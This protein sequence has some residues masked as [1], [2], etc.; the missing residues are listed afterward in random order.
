MLGQALMRETADTRKRPGLAVGA[1]LVVTLLRGRRGGC[2]GRLLGRV[3]TL[4]IV[5]TRPAGVLDFTLRP[6]PRAA[7]AR[8]YSPSEPALRACSSLYN[9]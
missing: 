9:L 1:L 4:F 6:N 5:R 8:L 7:R 3:R 2:P